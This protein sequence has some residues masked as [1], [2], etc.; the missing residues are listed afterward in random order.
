MKHSWAADPDFAQEVVNDL[1]RYRFKSHSTTRLLHLFTGILGGHRFYLGKPL[2]GLIFLLS[3]G[4]GLVLWIWDFTQIKQLVAEHNKIENDRQQAGLAPQGLSFLPPLAKLD[5]E[6]PPVWAERRNKRSVL[7]GGF[8]L[9][10]LIGLTMGVISGST[11]IIEP[12]IIM[13]VLMATTLVS[14]RWPGMRNIPLLRELTRWNHRLRLYYLTT[15][16][17]SIWLLAARPIVGV[18]IAP[19][20]KQSRAEVRLYLQ[21]GIAFGLT[22]TA[23]DAYELRDSG[24]WVAFGLSLAELAQTVVYTYVFVAP[25]GA[26]LITQQLLARKDWVVLLMCLTTLFTGYLGLLIVGAV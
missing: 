10:A 18:F 4:G 16:P 21:L 14:A 6:S 15:D 9:L 1:Y 13:V 22:F 7:F 11:E 12:P 24:F 5:L 23:V 20:R 3:G 25:V 19:W 17:G 26:I 2:S 8:A